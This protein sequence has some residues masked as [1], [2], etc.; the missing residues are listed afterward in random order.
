MR[1]A[2]GP[3][4]ASSVANGLICMP[5]LGPDRLRKSLPTQGCVHKDDHDRR[6]NNATDV[7]Q[8]TQVLPA[9]QLR[10][11]KNRVGHA[12]LRLL[13]RMTQANKRQPAAS[14]LLSF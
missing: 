9:L 3:S 11:V 6:D 8:K 7:Q 1:S 12:G 10:I 2:S 14:E 4:M 13:N 5:S